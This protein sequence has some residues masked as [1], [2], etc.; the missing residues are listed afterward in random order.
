M[1]IIIFN[2]TTTT[3]IYTLPLR[4]ALPTHH[5]QCYKVKKELVTQHDQ[6]HCL[7]ITLYHNGKNVHIAMS[8]SIWI[9]SN[10]AL[11]SNSSGTDKNPKVKFTMSMPPIKRKW[12]QLSI[13]LDNI[14]NGNEKMCPSHRNGVNN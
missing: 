11:E 14:S 13:S 3:H 9:S 2:A 8:I 10:N 5:F 1:D 4:D 12:R 7:M 6:P